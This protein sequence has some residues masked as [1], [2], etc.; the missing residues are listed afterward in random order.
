MSVDKF[1]FETNFKKISLFDMLIKRDEFKDFK[2]SELKHLVND[3]VVKMSNWQ[4]MLR[5]GKIKIGIGDKDFWGS[6]DTLIDI[7]RFSV[8]DWDSSYMGDQKF[9]EELKARWKE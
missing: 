7:F 4:L 9:K 5:D 1:L 3:I 8:L 6:E 2:V